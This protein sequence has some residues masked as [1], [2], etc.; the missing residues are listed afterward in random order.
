MGSFTICDGDKVDEAEACRNFFVS[1]REVG[2][3]RAAATCQ[4]LRELNPE[5]EG[6]YRVV[7]VEE[8]LVQEPDFVSGFG[9]VIGAQLSSVALQALGEACARHGV[10]LIV[11]R[12]CGLVGSVRLQCSGHQ[13]IDARREGTTWDLRLVEPL[14][15]LA[16][17]AEAVAVEWAGLTKQQKGHVPYVVLLAWQA[18]VWQQQH[19]QLPSSGAEK[20]EFRKKVKSLANGEDLDNVAEAVR[21]AHRVW[22]GPTRKLPEVVLQLAETDTELGVICRA[23]AR[24]GRCPIAGVLPD[25]HADTTQYVWLQRAY[26]EAAE[27]DVH[28][29]KAL[30]SKPVS[31]NLLRRACRHCRDLDLLKMRSLADELQSPDLSAVDVDED[32]D[33]PKTIDQAPV[34]WYLAL[35]AADRFT[36]K[37]KRWPN[38]ADPDDVH[39]LA[40]DLAVL[41]AGLSTKY[42]APAA[43]LAHAHDIA[44][45]QNVEVHATA[46]VVGAV[47]AQ[48]AIKIISRI[49]RPL[50]HTFLFNAINASAAVISP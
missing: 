22:S 6:E 24:L 9:L 10:A 31:D 15:A 18:K 16:D 20:D 50:N 32:G 4:L 3:P 5:S 43:W 19:E 26:A 45:F 2:R 13:V 27:A 11:V 7:P 8:L 36:L 48:E 30:L 46:A 37:R 14:A 40:T 49:Y 42:A 17:K 38:S 23:I 25:M 35:R 41:G 21:E 44:R 34:L 12:T 29:V 28:A 47:A 33:D 39:D 1:G